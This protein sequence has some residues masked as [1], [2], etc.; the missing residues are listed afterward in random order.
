MKLKDLFDKAENGVFTYDQLKAAIETAKAN[1]V[2]L[3]EGKYVSKSKYDDDISNRDTS[4]KQYTDTIAQRDKDLADLRT[5]L[6]DAGTDATK[7]AELSTNFENLQ[8]KYDT[9]IKNYQ[10]QIAKQ[11]YEF[12]VKE[13]AGTK[14]FTSNAAKRD[15]VQSMIAKDL[16]FENNTIIGADDFVKLYSAENADAFVAEQQN[17]QQ[18]QTK[19]SFVNSTPGVN[20]NPTPENAFINA[21]N[22]TGVR[23]PNQK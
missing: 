20:N 5:K 4:I 7:L 15:F 1:F 23:P 14:Q 21:F 3:S 19:P 10:A 22:F 12:A 16:K 9:D 13:F 17:Q 2:D 11:A 6:K 8:S 18:Q